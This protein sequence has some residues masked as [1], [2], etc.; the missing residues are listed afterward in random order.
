MLVLE[1]KDGE[2]I[3]IGGIVIVKVL[4]WR[5]GRVK[6]GI[7]APREVSVHRREIED[8]IMYEQTI[9]VGI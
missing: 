3:V 6:L 8:K 7:R 1:R 9:G 5:D 4:Q 2:E